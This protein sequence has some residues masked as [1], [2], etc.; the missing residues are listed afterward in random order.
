[1]GP[2]PEPW[3]RARACRMA[4]DRLDSELISLPSWTKSSSR[5]CRSAGAASSSTVKISRA[6]GCCQIGCSARY[7]TLKPPSPASATTRYLSTVVPTMPSGSRSRDAMVRAR[8]PCESGEQPPSRLLVVPGTPEAQPRASSAGTLGRTA[9]LATP[10]LDGGAAELRSACLRAAERQGRP[11][12][13][14]R[15][16]RS[17]LLRRR[18]GPRWRGGARQGTARARRRPQP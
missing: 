12:R 10:G 7:T 2:R 15:A 5:C 8:L 14:P 1:M 16:A 18:A 9:S 4:A 11:T 17:R 13:G 3:R 6:T